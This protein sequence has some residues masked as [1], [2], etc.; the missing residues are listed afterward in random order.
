M[1]RIALYRIPFLA[2]S[3]IAL[4]ALPILCGLASPAVGSELPPSGLPPA[5][6]VKCAGNGE[7]TVDGKSIRTGGNAVEAHG[8]CKVTLVGSHVVADGL[9]VFASGNGEVTIIDS[10]VQGDEL[11]V[12]VTGNAVVHHRGSTLRG[13]HQAAS[14]GTYADD[15]GSSRERIPTHSSAL[16]AH[17]A[18]TCGGDDN[19]TVIGK[20]IRTDGD[21][22]VV[23]GECEIFISDSH[24]EA[25]GHGIVITGAGKVRLRNSVVEGDGVAVVL[26][27]DGSLDTAGATF[28]GSITKGEGASRYLDLGGNATR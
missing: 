11:A 28:V 12:K 20:L 14:G 5:D 4:L 24:I 1:N 13:G 17:G 15:G 6:P 25:G 8:N 21:A 22:V 10:F 3:A 26:E 27:E 7:I 18:I 23:E 19:V 2:A 16:E 9:A